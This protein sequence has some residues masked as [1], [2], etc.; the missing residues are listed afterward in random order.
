ML[1]GS[2]ILEP[3]TVL[4]LFCGF[5][6]IWGTVERGSERGETGFTDHPMGKNTCL[7]V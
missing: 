5:Y 2:W 6:Y 7:V 1:Y 4:M 3:G